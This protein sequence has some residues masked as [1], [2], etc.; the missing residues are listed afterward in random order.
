MKNSNKNKIWA[1]IVLDSLKASNIDLIFGYPGWAN[2]PFYDKLELRDDIKHVLVRNEQWAW[3]AAQWISRTKAWLGCCMATSWPWIANMLTPIMDAYMDNIPLICLAGQVPYSFLWNDVFQEMDVIWSTMSFVKHWFLIKDVNDIP[4]I[5]N[6]AVRLATTWRPWPVIIDIPKDV[7]N[8]EYT[9]SEIIWYKN[10]ENFESHKLVDFKKEESSKIKEIINLLN[11]AKK[12]I[13]L[14]GQWVKLSNAEEELNVLLD[15][16]QIPSVTTL[17]AKWVINEWNKNYLWMLGMHGFYEANIAMSEADLIFNI[18]S[19]FDDR[20]VWTYESFWKN[21]KIIQVDIDKS[22]INKLVKVNIWVNSDAKDFIKEFLHFIKKDKNTNKTKL[23]LNNKELDSWKKHILELR[24]KHPFEKETKI[25]SIKN[26]CNIINQNTKSNLKNF[27]I[28]TDV[29]QHQMYAAQVLKVANTSSWLTSWWAWTMWFALPVAIGSAFWNSDKTHIIIVWDWWVQ[30]NIQELQVIAEHNL[31]IKVI[32]MNNWF[33]W[34]VR[35]WQDMF[36]KKNYASTRITS[37]DYID[38]AKAYRIDW[39]KASSEQEL[40]NILKKE[41]NKKWP[42][43]IEVIIKEK[44]WNIFP[45]VAPNT[46][47]SETVVK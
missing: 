44:E 28:I 38:L 1:D 21:A 15:N 20:I 25:F 14:I 35:Q 6:E 40:N 45:M 9:W 37:P 26:A 31:D 11:N 4:F 12:P 27:T 24:D 29:W 18:W 2:I 42:A 46:S 43:I 10:S 5:I 8:A 41:F 17:L 23:K 34:M 19:R 22:E 7:Q 3:F 16:L 36:Y 33:L 39:H 30:M 47:L 32:I 13:F